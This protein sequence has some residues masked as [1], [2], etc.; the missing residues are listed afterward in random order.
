[1][2]APSQ[3]TNRVTLDPARDALVL[4]DVIND[5]A[6]PG[7]ERVLPW[8]ERLAVPLLRTRALCRRSGVPV[9]YVNDNY[10]RW[11]GE[12]DEVFAHCTRRGAPGAHVSRRLR[13]GRRDCFLVKPRHS[14][15]FGT[16]LAPLL[17]S[18]GRTRIV[19]AGIATN[20]CVLATAHDATAHGLTLVVLS[21]CCAAENDFDHNVVLTQLQRYFK[22]TVCRAAEF[23]PSSRR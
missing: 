1:M 17:Q 5:L 22:A 9:I 8:A 21:D 6:F 4:V 12:R 14:A 19:L 18:R 11:S 15:F 23:S 16:P 3:K 2:S 20:M 7:A 13:P 10:G